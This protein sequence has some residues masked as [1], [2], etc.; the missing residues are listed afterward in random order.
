MSERHEPGFTLPTGETLIG[1]TEDGTPMWSEPIAEASLPC[2][3]PSHRALAVRV[4][5]LET[6][7]RAAEA[8]LFS[9]SVLNTHT[10]P[11]ESQRMGLRALERVR[12]LAGLSAGP[13][14]DKAFHPGANFDTGTVPVSGGETTAMSSTVNDAPS[15]LHLPRLPEQEGT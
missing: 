2:M 15:S 10:D 5:T 4:E 6:A 3:K 13:A 11:R 9:W 7:L 8:E 1:Y 12:A 14:N